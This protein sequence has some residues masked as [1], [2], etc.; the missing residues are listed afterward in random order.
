M[1]STAISETVIMC[2]QVSN[3]G[4]A[5]K[6]GRKFIF[7]E[8]NIMGTACTIQQLCGRCIKICFDW[9]SYCSH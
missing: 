5:G 7:H 1:Y 4:N 9:L 6:K 2:T 3:N 8:L